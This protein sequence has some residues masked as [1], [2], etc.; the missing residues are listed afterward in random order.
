VKQTEIYV[1]VGM[2]DYCTEHLVVVLVSSLVVTE[3][4]IHNQRLKLMLKLQLR[5]IS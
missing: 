4:F 5:C 1:E 3:D 2:L